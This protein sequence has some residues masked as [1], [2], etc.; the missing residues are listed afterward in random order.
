MFVNIWEVI[1]N[2]HSAYYCFKWNKRLFPPPHRSQLMRYPSNSFYKSMLELVHDSAF[3]PGFAICKVNVSQ[4][5][6][7]RNVMRLKKVTGDVLCFT[8]FI[9][10]IFSLPP[11]PM[12]IAFVLWDVVNISKRTS[13][14]FQRSSILKYLEDLS[15]SP[16]R[17][18]GAGLS[19]FDHTGTTKW[20]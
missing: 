13:W 9:P 17:G 16:S 4:F 20:S 7:V 14:G 6:M 2:T 1:I 11:P 19:A 8:Q 10:S 3:R 15:L 12:H 5:P 18:W